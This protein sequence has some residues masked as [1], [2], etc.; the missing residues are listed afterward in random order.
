MYW[1]TA[2]RPIK[3]NE[4]MR[5]LFLLPLFCV[6]LSLAAQQPD[7]LQFPLPA[8]QLS[9]DPE[10]QMPRQIEPRNALLWAIIPGGGQVYNRKWWKVP[11][12]YGALFGMVGVADYNH[13]NYKRVSAALK[14]ECFGV[15]PP[16]DPMP[17]EFS[18]RLTVNSLRSLRDGF[19]RNRQLSWLGI[20]LVYTLQGVEAYVDAHLQS[21][22]V[23]DDLG[24]RIEPVL[25]PAPGF[26]VGVS[27]SLP[28]GR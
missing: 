12:V 13:S 9:P 14:A 2:A 19:D 3:A 25:M 23:E 21:F 24:L 6:S 26:P 4:M 1:C 15:E 5:Y 27:V 11:L 22:D 10:L 16:C 17:H 8:G 7:T 28:I 20:F 18:G